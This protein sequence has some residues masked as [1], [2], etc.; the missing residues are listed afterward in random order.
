VGEYRMSYVSALQRCLAECPCESKALA[1]SA[2]VRVN[3]RL[4]WTSP[5]SEQGLAAGNAIFPVYSITKTLTAI[6]VSLS[7]TRSLEL[8]DP[9]RKWLPDLAVGDGI[10][11]AHLL[12]HR[13]GLAAYPTRPERCIA[14][15]QDSAP[16]GV[17]H[18]PW[19]SPT[20]ETSVVG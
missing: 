1:V 5:D 17:R 4:H 11:L 10:T 13:S 6:C 14:A 18:L 19:P 8:N 20:S 15:R 2:A 9:V 3:G 16:D 12:R 7:E